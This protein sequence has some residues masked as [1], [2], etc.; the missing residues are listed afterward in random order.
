MARD[1]E[2]F[3]VICVP[4]QAPVI[5]PEGMGLCGAK[6]CPIMICGIIMGVV[7]AGGAADNERACCGKFPV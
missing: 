4:L 2:G 1:V 5:V 3:D 7:P 6:V